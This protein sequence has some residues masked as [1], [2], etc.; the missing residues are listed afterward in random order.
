MTERQM[1]VCRLRG[2]AAVGFMLLLAVSGY[3]QSNLAPHLVERMRKDIGDFGTKYVDTYSDGRVVE[4]V[5]PWPETPVAVHLVATN[6]AGQAWRL[7]YQA[8]YLVAGVATVRTNSSFQLKPREERLR[9]DRKALLPP[10]PTDWTEQAV[11]V[12]SNRPDNAFAQ[13]AAR[14][15][16]QITKTNLMA[17]TPMVVEQ[18]LDSGRLVS[19]MSD[20]SIVT[21]VVQRMVTARV[22]VRT[23][24][25]P[26]ESSGGVPVGAAGAAVALAIAAG[27]AAGRAS[28]ST[29]VKFNPIDPSPGGDGTPTT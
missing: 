1:M 17:R 5:V 19:R 14:H 26:A 4:N 12:A 3:A 28:K 29:G 2:T 9:P 10:D 7:D 21:G 16:E 20:G 13:I 15:V 24:G 27:V 6:D 8:T 25:L 22:S 11:E 23:P 18:R